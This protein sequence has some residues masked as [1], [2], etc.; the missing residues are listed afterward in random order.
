MPSKLSAKQKE[1]YEELR[2][3]EGDKPPKA[4]KG[5]FDKFRDAFS[6]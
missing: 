3:L 1:L 5:F 6:G 4:E 2:K